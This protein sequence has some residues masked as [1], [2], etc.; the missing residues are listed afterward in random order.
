M[1]L[2]LS[3]SWEKDIR[4]PS[5]SH[6]S[7]IDVL[8]ACVP[9]CQVHLEFTWNP[10]LVISEKP[11]SGIHQNWAMSRSS[12]KK[13]DCTSSIG[14]PSCCISGSDLTVRPMST[15]RSTRRTH[16]TQFWRGPDQFGVKTNGFL[17][18]KL[19]FS[20]NPS[21]WMS[22]LS[23]VLYTSV[24][25]IPYLCPLSLNLLAYNADFIRIPMN[26][27][28]KKVPCSVHFRISGTN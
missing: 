20:L 11:F 7:G 16:L 23:V 24:Y 14:V 1:L 19:R 28:L 5:M 25:R 12:P 10:K 18:R 2:I 26:W 21:I 22:D 9:P 6:S 13:M 15:T 27:G 3:T 8:K 17:V 4:F